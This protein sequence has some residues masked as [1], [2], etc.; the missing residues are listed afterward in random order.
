MAASINLPEVG[1]TAPA[2]SGV[3]EQ[4]EKIR[5]SQY[6]GK[7]V[8]LYFYPKDN[9]PGCTVEAKEFRD[10]QDEFEGANAVVIGVSPDGP[11]SHCKFIDRF[12]LNFTLLADEDH[13][14]AEKYGVWIEKNMYG[15]KFMGIQRATFL[16]DP[17]GKISHV[18]PK[19]RAAGHAEQV[20][21]ML[22]ELGK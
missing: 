17:K 8:V 18:W 10:A 21:K 3:T 7:N 11:E 19:V 13:K 9:T 14:V 6:K 16:I 2:F 15:K 22:A 4:G 20:V 1:K 12:E 5:L